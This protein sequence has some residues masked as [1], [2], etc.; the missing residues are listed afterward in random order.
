[1]FYRKIL[2]ISI[3]HPMHN[4]KKLLVTNL[5]FVCSISALSAAVVSRTLVTGTN[6]ID[7]TGGRNDLNLTVT[8]AATKAALEG[9]TDFGVMQGPWTDLTPSAGTTPTAT[10]TNIFTFEDRPDVSFSFVGEPARN[11][12]SGT[13][14][15]AA[16][17]SGPSTPEGGESLFFGTSNSNVLTIEFGSYDALTTTF[18]ANAGVLAAG[19]TFSRNTAAAV[20]TTWNVSFYDGATLLSAQTIGAGIATNVAAL[21]GYIAQPGEEITR[22]VVGGAGSA[23]DNKNHFVDDFGFAPVPEPAAIAGLLGILALGWVVW[24]R[25]RR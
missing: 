21:F 25:R 2:H 22:I 8:G 6:A 24:Q 4:L 14:T 19:L 9:V 20:A 7:P 15:G 11:T 23:Y 17:T 12:Q 16:Y 18:T 13:G 10:S 5:L 3:Q 1:L